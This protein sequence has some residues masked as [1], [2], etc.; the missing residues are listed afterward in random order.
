M[1]GYDLSTLFTTVPYN[2]IIEKLIE[3]IEQAF[4]IQMT[5]FTWRVMRNALFTCEQ[6]IIYNL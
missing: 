3:L 1:S 5:P 4:V 2:L 6:S